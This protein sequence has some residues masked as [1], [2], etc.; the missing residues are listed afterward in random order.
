[1][2]RASKLYDD[3]EIDF[4]K[5]VEADPEN[6]L[7]QFTYGEHLVKTGKGKKAIPHLEKAKELFS[8]GKSTGM[9][10]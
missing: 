9:D 3:Y 7:A 8:K 4:K 6:P 5:S 1:M 10:T 2:K